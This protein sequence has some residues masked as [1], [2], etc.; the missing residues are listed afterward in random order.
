[1]WKDIMG[2]INVPQGVPGSNEGVI[3]IISNGLTAVYAIAGIATM[4]LL[5]LG[6]IKIIMS[7]G[8][9]DKLKEGRDTLSNAIL[10]IFVVLVSGL[11]FQFLGKLLY[12]L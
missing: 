5:V 4:A 6:G 7:E 2:N 8:N 11:V 12:Y 9:P 3:A 1:M 10:G